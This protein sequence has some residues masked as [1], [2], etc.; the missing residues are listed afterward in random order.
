M[1]R[2]FILPIVLMILIVVAACSGEDS[3][4]DPAVSSNAEPGS[5]S[6]E[7]ETDS[8]LQEEES[9]P[10]PGPD[11]INLEITLEE[12]NTIEKEIGTEG[13][14][15]EGLGADGTRYLLEIP[16]DAL[17]S[18]ATIRLTPA[19]WVN[20]LPFEGE[21]Q[22]LVNLEPKGLVFF[23]PAELSI[24]PAAWGGA[25]E[26]LAYGSR[27]F[28]E[29]FHLYPEE[30]IEGGL[31][32]RINHFSNYGVQN[33][34]VQRVTKEYVPSEAESYAHDQQATIINY[35]DGE[36]AQLEALVKIQREWFTYSVEVNLADAALDA[37]LI[38]RAVGEFL[39]WRSDIDSLDAILEGDGELA[40]RLSSEIER[41]LEAMAA[42]LKFGI[43]NA[44]D[45]CV[46]EE[47]FEASLRMVRYTLL[48]TGLDLW[49]R[50]GLDQDQVQQQFTTC[51]QFEFVF[52]SNFEGTTKTNN[53]I[54][55]V[56]AVV[57][58]QFL[59]GQ[60]QGTTFSDTAPLIFIRNEVDLA[61]FG[62]T[63]LMSSNET[64]ISASVDLDFNWYLDAPKVEAIN[65]TMA[66]LGQPQE[67]VICEV[68]GQDVPFPLPFW[69]PVFQVVYQDLFEGANLVVELPVVREGATFAEIEFSGST[70]DPFDG[71]E[72]SSFQFIHT[73]GKVE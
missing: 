6:T 42:A 2:K 17:S 22:G 11:P 18:T 56:K 49:G 38:D 68:G 25:G 12:G 47:D 67:M 55:A 24:F 50:S 37:D 34:E 40:R 1:F 4:A 46:V 45:S 7:L 29:D 35:I 19:E 65:V 58:F 9:S 5:S 20:G 61:Q 14:S 54:S 21:S 59:E 36:D 32:L 57:P 43:E 39:S 63:C 53:K 41:G 62:D 10:I 27:D 30:E 23:T 44:Y 15:L 28:G 51:F 16:P 73:P 13:G 60:Q 31:K 33:A 69:R 66:F 70:P 48:T 64:E 52:T 3:G 72:R 71:E 8:P 26:I